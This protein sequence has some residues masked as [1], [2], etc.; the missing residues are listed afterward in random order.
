MDWFWKAMVTGALSFAATNVDDIFVLLLFFS[1]M[2]SRG[3]RTWPVVVGQY[4]GFATLVAI[5]LAGYFASLAVPRPWIGLLGLLPIAIG[6]KKFVEWR[7]GASAE[8]EDWSPSARG[9]V[10]SVAGVT[11]A[12]GGDNIGIYTPLFA[13]TGSVRELLTLLVVYFALIALWCVA[14]RWLSGH[15]YVAGALDRYGHLLVPVVLTGLGIWIL[16]E[17]GTAG[18]IW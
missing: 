9:S 12:N 2:R 14:G 5:S 7:Q 1:E 16:Y 18:L 13:A 17:S 6:I 11:I 3:L 15:K 10:L 8:K 4:L